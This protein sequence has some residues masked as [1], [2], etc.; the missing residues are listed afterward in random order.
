VAPESPDVHQLGVYTVGETIFAFVP[1]SDA[2]GKLE[3]YEISVA[4]RL[5]ERF[6]AILMKLQIGAHRF[7]HV[8]V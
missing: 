4:D 2:S 8:P 7:S 5:P 6:L 3:I 1:V